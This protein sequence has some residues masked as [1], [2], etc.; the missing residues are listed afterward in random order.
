LSSKIINLRGRSAYIYALEKK[1][2]ETLTTLRDRIG[3]IYEPKWHVYDGDKK[4]GILESWDRLTKD[5][6]RKE[7]YAKLKEWAQEFFIKDEWLLD[8]ALDTLFHGDPR[9]TIA[10]GTGPKQYHWNY[11]S[12]GFHGLF[13]PAL[14]RNVWYPPE[15]GWQEDWDAFRSRMSKQFNRQLSEYRKFVMGRLVGGGD[16]QHA[17]DA[18]WAVLYNK[19]VRAIDIAA[20]TDL[21]GYKDSEDAVFKAIQRFARGIDLTLRKR[22]ER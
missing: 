20:Q 18:T 7:L 11:Y 22:G 19:G 12:R 15:H 8:A 1:W 13:E 2:P 4:I 9:T 17:R 16:E 5:E 3:P 10:S 14:E 21:I 6:E